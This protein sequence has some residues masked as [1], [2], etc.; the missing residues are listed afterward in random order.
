MGSFGRQTFSTERWSLTPRDKEKVCLP[1]TTT[2]TAVKY[3]NTALPHY[4]LGWAPASAPEIGVVPKTQG[5]THSC[6]HSCPRRHP[7]PPGELPCPFLPISKVHATCEQVDTSQLMA[8]PRAENNWQIAGLRQA[9]MMVTT[10][11]LQN[12]TQG[13]SCTDASGLAKPAYGQCRRKGAMARK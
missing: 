1:R 11:A 10:S 9:G 2:M 6:P 7:A 12:P 3:T 4:L 5:I 8:V 13:S